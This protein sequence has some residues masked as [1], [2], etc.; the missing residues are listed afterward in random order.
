MT[1]CHKLPRNVE[2]SRNPTSPNG[3]SLQLTSNEPTK[4]PQGHWPP[5]ASIFYSS[6][7]CCDEST[8]L[9]VYIYVYGY[10][11][12]HHH[13]HHHHHFPLSSSPNCSWWSSPARHHSFFVFPRQPSFFIPP[14]NTRT[15]RTAWNTKR[16]TKG[17]TTFPLAFK[18][19]AASTNAKVLRAWQSTKELKV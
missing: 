1:N 11:D 17:V 18:P 5:K 16:C 6:R 10:D 19:N 3:D 9:Y 14:W 8:R 4:L 2:S 15:T 7:V 12:Q 13:H